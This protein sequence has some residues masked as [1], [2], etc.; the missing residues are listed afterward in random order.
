MFGL[1]V[2]LTSTEIYCKMFVVS[3]H[4]NALN[5]FIWGILNRL[6]IEIHKMN[7][8]DSDSPFLKLIQ[9]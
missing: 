2:N 8:L 9:D 7:Q 6:K 5:K 3:Y 4:S 1:N